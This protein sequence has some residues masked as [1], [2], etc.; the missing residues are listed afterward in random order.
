MVGFD[1]VERLLAQCEQDTA[2]TSL[3]PDSPVRSPRSDGICL[4]H[5]QRLNFP[6][7][8]IQ[9][10]NVARQGVTATV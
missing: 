9:F 1:L 8:F 2:N 6:L 4:K 10:Q 3:I 7:H 5:R